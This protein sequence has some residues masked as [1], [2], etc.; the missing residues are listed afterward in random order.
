MFKLI[1]EIAE[2]HVRRTGWVKP[3]VVAGLVSIFFFALSLEADAA[4]GGQFVKQAL[5]T[6]YGKIGAV[7]VG[8]LLLGLVILLLP[9]FIYALYAES[10]G[11]RKTKADLA[12]LAAKYR[13]FDWLGIRDRVNKA[14]RDIAGVWATGN[15]SSVAPL[16]TPEYF[17]TQQASLQRWIDEGKQIVYRLEKVRKIE[18]LAVSVESAESYSWIRVLVSVDCVDYMR[19][20]LTKEICKGEIDVTKGFESVWCFVYRDRQWLLNGIE[21]GSTSLTWA[22]TKNSIDTSYLE[23]VGKPQRQVREQDEMPARAKGKSQSASFDTPTD[24]PA[25]QPKQRLVRKPADDD[26]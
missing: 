18:P 9:L 11:I 4:P 15:L 24:E 23:T 3:F 17:G 5:S 25:A 1:G 6:K 21:E 7:I 2:I 20:E 10:S 22:T 26:E 8:C 19:D 13:W 12:V 14:V 16:M